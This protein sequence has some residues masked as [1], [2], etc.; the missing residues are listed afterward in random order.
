MQKLKKRSGLSFR[1]HKR[2]Q[3]TGEL[4]LAGACILASS[5]FIGLAWGLAELISHIVAGI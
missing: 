5:A 4:V 3:L 2:L 1:A